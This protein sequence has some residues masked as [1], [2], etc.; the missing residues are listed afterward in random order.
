MS[1]SNAKP[2]RPVPLGLMR[3]LVTMHALAVFAQPVLAGLFLNGDFDMVAVHS[4]NALLVQLL[5]LVQI[6]IAIL[7]RWPGKGPLWPVWASG[8]L[9][10]AESAQ[11]S[12]G[13]IRMLDLHI[14]LGVAIVSA[15]LMMLAWVWRPRLGRPRPAPVPREAEVD[16]DAAVTP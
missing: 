11:A 10:L 7:L 2:P 15:V 16:A 3:L 13:Y 1:R 5:G 14:P 6:P 4:T 12:F 8:L 9:F